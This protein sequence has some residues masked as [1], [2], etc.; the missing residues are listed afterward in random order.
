MKYLII[1]LAILL[2]IGSLFAQSDTEKGR[3][4]I[5]MISVPLHLID[6]NNNESY[7]LFD[8]A[9]K[10]SYEHRVSKLFTPYVQVGFHGPLTFDLET[11]E[12]QEEIKTAGINLQVGNKFYFNSNETP[13]GFYMSPQF[14]FNSIKLNEDGSVPGGYIKIQDYGLAGILGYQIVR[15]KGFAISAYTGA[16]VFRRN[17]YDDTMIESA[18]VINHNETGIRPY[19]G[20]Q[21][22]YAF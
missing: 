6:N 21:F 15:S 9:F 3:K 19:L 16:G 8:L 14:T 17:Y 20:F 12:K 13:T 2:P 7:F 18:T 5:V 11:A 22:G 10:A 1:V 4:N